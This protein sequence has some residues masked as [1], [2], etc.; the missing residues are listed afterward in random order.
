[1]NWLPLWALGCIFGLVGIWWLGCD[2]VDWIGG[3]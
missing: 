1:M 3:K 2:L